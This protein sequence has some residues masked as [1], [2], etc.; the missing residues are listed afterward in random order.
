MTEIFAEIGFGN[1]TFL[2]TEFENKKTQKE[3]RKKGFILAKKIDD[4]Y[5]R[6]WI[7]KKVYIFSFKEGFKIENKTHNKFKLLFGISGLDK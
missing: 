6:I 2:S 4:Y 1:E 7:I 5:I 3:Y